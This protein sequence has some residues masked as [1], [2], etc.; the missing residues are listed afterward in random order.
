MHAAACGNDEGHTLA[1]AGILATC[2]ANGFLI[3]KLIKKSPSEWVSG[4]LLPGDCLVAI[5]GQDLSEKTLTEVTALL[6]GPPNTKVTIEAKRDMKRPS[7][8][9]TLRR[10]GME[11]DTRPTS[12]IC[13]QA[14]CVITEMRIQVSKIDQKDTEACKIAA[15]LRDAQAAAKLHETEI[16]S[17]RQQLNSVKR[18]KKKPTT[19]SNM[20]RKS[21]RIGN[22]VHTSMNRR[23]LR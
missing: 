20:S 21:A 18:G 12:E 5:D 3:K 9:V 6:T 11:S 13:K 15:A 2:D 17:L 7:Y 23:Y 14:V 4:S 19:T 10:A 1:G 16:D 22:R 8:A